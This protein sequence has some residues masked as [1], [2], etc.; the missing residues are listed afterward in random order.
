MS[1][2]II[3]IGGGIAGLYTT[4]NL[5]KKYPHIKIAL[6]EKENYLGGRIYTDTSNDMTIEAGAG[7][8]SGSHILLMNLIHE[9]GLSSKLVK[10]SSQAVYVPSDQPL[11][12]IQKYN[13]ILDS[14]YIIHKNRDVGRGV[15]RGVGRGVGRDGNLSFSSLLDST[16]IP[17]IAN[18][19]NPVIQSTEDIILGTK[20]LPNAGLLIRV[21]LASKFESREYLSSM[22]FE[23]YAKTILSEP[24]V[25]F[26]KQSF[27]FY[28]ELVIM[29]AHD[30]IVLMGNLSPSNQF[31]SLNGGLSQIVHKMVS[32]ITRK[33]HNVQIF[34]GKKVNDIKWSSGGGSGVGN[35]TI[36]GEGSKGGL[37][38]FYCKKCIC[39]VT[40]RTLEKW[41]IIKPYTNML[42]KIK[43][44]P[45]CRIYCKFNT[46]VQGGVWFKDL[47][48]MTTNNELRMI[49]PYDVKN[50]VIM[51][52]YT[53]NVFAEYWLNL[54][55]KQGIRG[56]NR[57]LIELIKKTL[58]I[59]I[60]YPIHTRICYWSCGVGYWGVGANSN[61][62]SNAITK[63][64]DFDFYVCGE[65]FS[66][67]NQQ[68]M[69][70]ALDTS[71]RVLSY[72]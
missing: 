71:Q 50:G 29:N 35:F 12:N 68:W 39:A 9:L 20:N 65:H 70:G 42:S 46:N 22:S 66:E 34:M 47:D 23:K 63:P 27:G 36:K 28:S 52:S 1:F 4:Y 8:L 14:Q 69:E 6:I 41:K 33:K 15:R 30:A 51:I 44:S 54:K 48:K 31:Y 55:N 7:R 61:E 13:S 45:L 72:L 67:K 24:E 59:D 18:I 3:V 60:P 26:I 19:I 43:C 21:I 64:F 2:D 5:L 32:F 25:E 16:F 49:I 57:R 62:I 58:G 38:T 37:F 40:A 56:V 11:D 53:D 10:I 17:N